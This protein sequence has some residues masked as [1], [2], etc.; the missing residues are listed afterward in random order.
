MIYNASYSVF[1]GGQ[2]IAVLNAELSLLLRSTVWGTGKGTPDISPT[3]FLVDVCDKIYFAGWGSNLGGPLSTLN[4]PVS[5]DAYQEDTDGNDIYLMVLDGSLSTMIYSTYFGGSQSNEHVDGGTSRFDKKGIIYQSVCAGC[6]GN[7]DFPIEP[8]PGAVS[9]TNNSPNCNNGVFKFDFNFPIVIADFE[10]PW[11]VCDTVINFQ[12][13]TLA[14][15]AVTYIWDFGDGNMSNDINPTHT[16]AQNGIHAITLIAIDNN[17][18]NIQDTIRKEIYILSNTSDSLQK[19]IKCPEEQIQVGLL[20]INN[21]AINYFWFPSINLSSPNISNPF[22]STNTDTEYQLLISDGSCTDTLF[23]NV[24]V[25]EL[26]LYAGPDTLYCNS[27]ILLI[28]TYSDEVNTVLW[29]SNRNFQDT[30]SVS[31]DLIISS[32][33]VFYIQVS[34]GNCIRIDSIEVYSDNIIDVLA[35]SVCLGDSTLIE[36][37]NLDL[38]SPIISYSWNTNNFDTV[39]FFDFPEANTWYVVEVINSDGC[40][41]R[42]SVFVE[43]Y[44]YPIVDSAWSSEY[45]VFIGE[46]ITLNIMTSYDVNWL[47]FSNTNTTQS[48]FPVETNCYEFEV[49]NYFC[50]INDSLCV[51]TQDVLCDSENIKIPTAFSPNNDNVNDT[52]F[53]DDRDG[54]VTSFKL[55]IFNRLGQKVFFTRDILQQWDGTFENNRL[56]PQIFDFYIDLECIGGKTLFKKGNITLI[57]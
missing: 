7:S 18:C 33:G 35:N 43:V 2:F 24:L 13:L 53:I 15:P 4:L 3:A 9:E 6:G 38:S 56:N 10:A 29:S 30:L 23:Q 45:S 8:L 42:D 51:E 46:E 20:P 49:Y 31:S 48:L 17:S 21:P 19:I 28:P 16:F 54:V 39:A 37:K 36:V 22:C 50:I 44:E 5:F 57:R 32:P 47:D 41:I 34:D 25:T 11:V 14:G 27:P 12:N 1:G 26:D 55:E 40:I 52:Y